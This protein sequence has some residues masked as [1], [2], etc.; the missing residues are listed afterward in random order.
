MFSTEVKTFIA[1]LS[2]LVSKKKSK[3]FGASLT[4]WVNDA[5]AHHG[6]TQQLTSKKKYLPFAKLF[7]YRDG[8]DEKSC[9]IRDGISRMIPK[10]TPY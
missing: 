8:A 4:L 1:N 9:G 3:H 10:D 6:S 2:D 5:G 7:D